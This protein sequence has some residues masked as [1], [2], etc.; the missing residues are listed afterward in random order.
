MMTAL[1]AVVIGFAWIGAGVV[2]GSIVGWVFARRRSETL[3][4]V[5]ESEGDDAE[6]VNRLIAE[7][8]G[9]PPKEAA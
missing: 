3:V 4:I 1:T 6:L 5:V 2:V 7:C 9:V 8:G